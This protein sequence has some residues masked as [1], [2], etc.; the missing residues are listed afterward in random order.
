M[1]FDGYFVFRCDPVRM[2]KFFFHIVFMVV[3]GGERK[4][5]LRKH[6]KL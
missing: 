3:L 6:N 2:G 5:I 1:G 4:T